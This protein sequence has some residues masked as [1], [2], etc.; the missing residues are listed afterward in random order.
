MENDKH[1][2]CDASVRA[3]GACLYA[4]HTVDNSTEV[5]LIYSRN[6]LAPVKK[7][8][9]P[10]LELLAALLNVRL[11]QNFCREMNMN[12]YT[13]ILWSNSTVILSWIKGDPNRWKTFICNRTTDILQYIIPTRWRHWPGTD[14]PVDHLTRG[15]FPSQ[16]STLESWW[17]SLK[18]LTRNPEIWPTNDLSSQPLLEV[19]LQKMEFQFFYVTTLEPIVDIY[20]Y[21][22]YT[23]L[24]LVV[25]WI[26]RFV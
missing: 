26:L 1:V 6:K 7:V 17:H 11:L 24:L 2:F 20:P 23:K 10:R 16:L 25:A 19:E 14:N 4:R 9:I 21:N 8:N 5:N 18:W 3:Y 13:A 22:S 15:T 12:S